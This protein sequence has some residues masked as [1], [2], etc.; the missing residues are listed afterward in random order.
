MLDIVDFVEPSSINKSPLREIGDTPAHIEAYLKQERKGNISPEGEAALKGWRE[1]PT[2]PEA[3]ALV[4]KASLGEVLTEAEG[5]KLKGHRE[6]PYDGMTHAASLAGREYAGEEL[7][8]EDDAHLQ[9]YKAFPHKPWAAVLV[10]QETLGTIS[11][12]DARRLASLRSK[13]DGNHSFG[14][15]SQLLT[16]INASVDKKSS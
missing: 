10:K 14:G 12:E 7:S 15:R 2:R 11:E 1:F 9:G 4:A 5:A 8:K 6:F 16:E 13:E 3:A